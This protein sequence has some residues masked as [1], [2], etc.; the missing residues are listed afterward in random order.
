MNKVCH[1]IAPFHTVLNSGTSHC[2]F[3]QKA[4]R[5]PKMMQALGYRVVEYSNGQSE[6]E[7]VE[8]VCMLT[9]RE[10]EALRAL[11]ARTAAAHGEAA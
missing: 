10:L 7:A 2:A 8:K 9:A 4:L 5:F 1:M 6:S 3:S 11:Y